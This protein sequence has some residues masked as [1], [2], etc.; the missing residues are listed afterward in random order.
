MLKDLLVPQ[1]T[2]TAPDGVM[3]PPAPAEAD[4]VIGNVA[5][6]FS[7]EFEEA[8][9]DG[10]TVT[11]AELK[12]AKQSTIDSIPK[13]IDKAEQEALKNEIAQSVLTI[14]LG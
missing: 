4:M 13:I 6:H 3:L 8:V 2:V 1:F 7:L 12:Q 11:A 9:N 14:K 10:G 5:K